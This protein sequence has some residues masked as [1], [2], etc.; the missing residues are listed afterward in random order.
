MFRNKNTN[1]PDYQGEYTDQASLTI[2]GETKTIAEILRH[3]QATGVTDARPVVY[4]D[5]EDFDRINHFFNPNAL[6]LT[7]LGALSEKIAELTK[8]VEEAQEKQKADSA[9]ADKQ[10]TIHEDGKDNN[11]ASTADD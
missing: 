4:M 10:N 7:D 2:Q 11:T 9:E 6:D 5:E 8:I 3:Y 1:K